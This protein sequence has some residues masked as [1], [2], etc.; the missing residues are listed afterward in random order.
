[1]GL[2]LLHQFTFLV[3]ARL[4]SITL[5]M[6]FTALLQFRRC[7]LG[8]ARWHGAIEPCVIFSI[9]TSMYSNNSLGASLCGVLVCFA[10]GSLDPSCQC[11]G[12]LFYL[13]TTSLSRVTAKSD[14]SPMN[15]VFVAVPGFCPLPP[16]SFTC[17]WV[18]VLVSIG[19]SNVGNGDG[20]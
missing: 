6:N 10:A 20:L 5:A 7:R 17:K 9:Q 2:R 12:T 4:V 14:N 3:Y 15:P 1:M 16:P 18:H 11:H 19:A 13:A 8:Q